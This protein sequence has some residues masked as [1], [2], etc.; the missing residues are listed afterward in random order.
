MYG[1]RR[2]VSETE[3]AELAAPCAQGHVDRT[4]LGCKRQR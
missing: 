2:A 1:R 4:G 3:F